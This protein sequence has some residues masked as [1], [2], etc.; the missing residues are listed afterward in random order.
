M[1]KIRDEEDEKYFVQP[2]ETSMG[3]HERNLEKM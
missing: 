1:N 2:E 3:K